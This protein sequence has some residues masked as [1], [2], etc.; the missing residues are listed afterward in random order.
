M[1][2][3]DAS[4]A[5]PLTN[6]QT[7]G[8]RRRAI[9]LHLA[10][11][12]LLIAVSL[13]DLVTKSPTVSLQYI[14]NSVTMV[15]GLLAL[16]SFWVA[17]RYDSTRG[18]IL[19]IASIL[20]I[21]LG[22]PFYAHGLGL[23]AGIITAIMATAAA[24]TTLRHTL[25]VR[26]SIIAFLVESVVILL[27]LYLP[28][29][30]L[31][32]LQSPTVNIF[33]LFV[34]IASTFYVLRQYRTY[35]LRGKLVI[36]FILVA[37]IAVSTVAFGINTLTR[38]R[39][40]Q[41]VGL[42]TQRIADQVAQELTST[43]LSE[44]RLLQTLSGQFEEIAEESA[45][46]YEGTDA[47]ITE[48]LMA[49]DE[50]WRNAADDH[51]LVR[52]TLNSHTADEL[53]ELQNIA[54]DHIEIFLTDR[55]GATIAASNRTSD[56]YQ[57]DEDW[58]LATYNSG[59]GAIYVGQPEFDESSQTY[60]INL[61]VP[62]RTED[63]P[64]VGILRSTL[65]VSV[66]GHLLEQASFGETGKV[67]LRLGQEELLGTRALTQDEITALDTLTGPFGQIP[68]RGRPSLVNIEAIQ[69]ATESEQTAWIS[70]LGWVVIV[71]Q[72]LEE[73]LQPVEDQEKTT[74]VIS[75]IVLVL[76]AL[77]GLF[78]SQRV[79]APIVSLTDVASQIAAGDLTTRAPI[80][81]DD[82]IGK[83]AHTFNLMTVQLGQTLISLEQRVAERTTELEMASLLSERRAQELQSI[84]EIS[85]LISVEQRLDKLLALVTRL[86]S[87]RFDFYHTGIFLV[88]ET[89]QYAILQATNSE[90][91]QK[92]L[93]RGHRLEVGQTGLVGKV[94][95][96]GQPRIALDVGTDAVYFDNPDLPAT[97]SE[98]AL[99]LNL[100][101][102]TIGVLDVQS[103]SPGAFTDNDA[104]TLSILA[105]QVAI[106]I[107]NARL[108]DQNRQS[109]A[110]VESLYNRYLRQEWH[111]FGHQ[112]S[113][114]G[115]FQSALGGRSLHRP[116]DSEE[117]RLA[118]QQGTVIVVEG[119]GEKSLPT[120]V[121]PVRLRG[122]TIGVL[123]IKAPTQNRRWSQEEINLAQA[124]SDRLALALDNARLLV[125]SQRQTAKEQKIGEVTAKIGA[126]I[127]MR[128]VLQTAVEELGRALPGSEVIIQ[129]ESNGKQA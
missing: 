76:A 110:E 4:N 68:F 115:Y 40:T 69:S 89:R 38:D 32:E 19:F 105:D 28:D 41:Q 17:Y 108:F 94:A 34:A 43:L 82:E 96:T 54:P 97:R 49:L 106:A 92:M 15:M 103:T 112:E 48:Q 25:A 124:V 102:V 27:D 6:D 2:I 47:E 88:D 11:G 23:Q 31:G 101:N 57:A 126:S 127:N 7:E 83:L 87:E 114:V 100:R 109:L 125:E 56:Y 8:Y 24:I 33:M 63:G 128:N 122:Q 26:A 64:V 81:S 119:K 1:N 50:V 104:K 9:R 71:H 66:L 61:A 113:H 120:I 90:G 46:E 12:L 29:F 117:I 20:A 36:F 78:A 53:R 30:G 75:M 59:E 58:W 73:A 70:K 3:P 111:K 95:Q 67:E 35:T 129:F 74:V 123:D 93:A 99:P 18:S 10:V 52:N 118:L 62:V 107:D 45:A 72:D 84:S 77:A 79:A 42:T 37:F 116:T 14:G 60:A 51:V 121:V 13:P 39:L 65:N 98:M 85:R 22:I 91:G 21:S 5:N 55:F 86:V 44:I 80:E 16:V